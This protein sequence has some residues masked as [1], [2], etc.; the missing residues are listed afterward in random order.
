ME[1][2]EYFSVETS[3]GL[4]T[5]VRTLKQVIARS[6]MDPGPKVQWEK[7]M[8]A[9]LRILESLVKMELARRIVCGFSPV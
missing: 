4:K 8:V 5:M 7:D 9:E 2:I 3:T 1:N 6:G